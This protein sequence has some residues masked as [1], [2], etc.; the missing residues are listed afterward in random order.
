MPSRKRRTWEVIIGLLVLIIFS[1]I[2]ISVLGAYDQENQVSSRI[3][4]Q[5]EGINPNHIAIDVKVTN[6][7]PINGTLQARLQFTPKGNLL[8]SDK[9]SLD[10][11]LWLEVNADRGKAEYE[12]K[13]GDAMNPITVTYSLFGGNANYYPFDHHN[14]LMH[15]DLSTPANKG[16]LPTEEEIVDGRAP[17]PEYDQVP[18]TIDFDGSYGGY[19][20]KVE[21]LDE[22]LIG[23]A[24]LSM[25]ISRSPTVITFACFVMLL[26]WLLAMTTLFMML[27]V[28]VRGRKVELSM[29]TWMAALLF[30]LPPLRNSMPDIPPIGSLPDFVAFFW[31]EGIVA[32]SLI[33]IAFTWLKRPPHK[34]KDRCELKEVEQKETMQQ[35]EF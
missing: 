5:K 20:L 13:R 3:Y 17:L 32:I 19:T 23:Y 16:K 10:K 22:D 33:C 24:D 2:Y 14:A 29:F 1:I 25:N 12:F 4:S 9:V 11:T 21:E 31:A 7:D 26:K 34:N 15:F 35:D 6:I 30:A 18:I 28:T 27:A 8:A